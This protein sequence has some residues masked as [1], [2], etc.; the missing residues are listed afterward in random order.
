MCTNEAILQKMKAISDKA[1]ALLRL[2]PAGLASPSLTKERTKILL[3]V[4]T[5]FLINVDQLR[6]DI[7]RGAEAKIADCALLK[8]ARDFIDTS[9]LLGQSM[10]ARVLERLDGIGTEHQHAPKSA[11]SC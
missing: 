2:V 1:D 4:C 11:R 6:G 10:Q 8:D 5:I 3:E 7:T 9:F